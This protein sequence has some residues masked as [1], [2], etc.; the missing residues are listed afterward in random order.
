MDIYYAFIQHVAVVKLLKQKYHPKKGYSICLHTL[1][2]CGLMKLSHL[3][4]SEEFR[5]G[6]TAALLSGSKTINDINKTWFSLAAL[7]VSII[8][9]FFSCNYNLSNFLD[10]NCN[11]LNIPATSKIL[12]IP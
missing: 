2:G 10:K 4:F 11:K 5:A 9:N 1:L 3:G 7:Q 8:A 12:Y 6:R